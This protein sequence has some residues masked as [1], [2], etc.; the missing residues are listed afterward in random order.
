MSSL[1]N[2]SP[3]LSKLT[4]KKPTFENFLELI[5]IVGKNDRQLAS[6]EGGFNPW[7]IAKGKCGG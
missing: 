3:E 5:Q 6:W 4:R 2:K 1:V 7:E